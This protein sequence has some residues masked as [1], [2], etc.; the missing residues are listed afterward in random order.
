[1][2]TVDYNGHKVY[3]RIPLTVYFL[4]RDK[5]LGL[6]CLGRKNWV[7]PGVYKFEAL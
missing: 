2:K 7:H 4:M 3:F 1:M 5:E 6:L